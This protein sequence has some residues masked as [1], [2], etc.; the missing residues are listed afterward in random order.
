[1]AIAT[2]PKP[3]A[4][5]RKRQAQHHKHTKRYV[6]AYWPYLPMLLIVGLGLMINSAWSGAVLGSTSDFSA[7]VLLDATNTQRTEQQQ[8]ALTIDPRL[9]AAAQAKADDMAA[10]NYWAHTAPDGK[11]PWTF[12]TASGYQYQ[13]AGENLAY[14][15][16]SAN[17][18][19]AGWMNSP[20]HRAN[21]LNSAYQHVGFGVASAPDYQGYGPQII[22]VAEYAQPVATTANITFTVPETAEN[23][24][25]P[26]VRGAD[27]ELAAKPVSRVQV[28]TDG[29]AAWATLAVGLIT[30]AA[31][32][33]FLTRHGFRLH[34]AIT[35]GEAFVAH[36][37]VFDIAIVVIVTAGFILTRTT[38]LIR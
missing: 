38:G 21:I 14:G 17:D 22:I 15:F 28:I 34:R 3:K 12:I 9:S 30:G 4:H 24:P 35:R 5:H 8:T 11:T 16:A 13:T 32:A 29:N 33:L 23:A 18:T 7:Q 27:T 31:L 10:Q 36:H 19:I 37:P 1:M 6:K 26:E 20:E 2:K 25:A